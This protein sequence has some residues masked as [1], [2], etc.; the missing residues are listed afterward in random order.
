MF[1]CV[2]VHKYLFLTPVFHMPQCPTVILQK[3]LI[4]ICFVLHYTML[5]N[6]RHRNMCG[7][8]QS[9]FNFYLWVHV[10]TMALNRLREN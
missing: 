5:F 2:C 10:L 9:A 4:L 1:L 3:L 8:Q 6:K 7:L